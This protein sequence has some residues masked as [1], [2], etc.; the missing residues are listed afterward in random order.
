MQTFV[1]Q[2][3][4]SEEL[5]DQKQHVRWH[6]DPSD[7]GNSVAD[8]TLVLMLSDPFDP[9]N[10]W[11][12]GELLLKNGIPT[13]EGPAVLVTP[14]YN[15]AVLFNNK[16]N[17]HLVTAIKNARNGTARNIVIINVYLNDPSS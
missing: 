6:Q 10:G 2:S 3:L 1:L 11:E 7:Y 15:Q 17:S 14:K 4:L 13:E 9:S 16:K 12:G 8:Y 5:S